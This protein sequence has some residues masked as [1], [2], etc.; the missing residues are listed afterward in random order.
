MSTTTH[1]AATAAQPAALTAALDWRYAVKKFDPT[2]RVPDAT[3]SVLEHALVH[4]PS[5]YGLQ[6]W[7]FVVVADPALRARLREVSWKQSQVTDASHFV[8]FA[9]RVGIDSAYVQHYVER[10]AAVRGVPLES[11]N[12]FRDM[13]NKAI[14][15][16]G[17]KADA[18]S[19]RQ[20][21]IALGALLTAAAV[22]GVDA[23]PMEGIDGPRYDELLGLTPLGYR[24]LCAAAVGYR[25]ADDANAALRKVRFAPGEVILRR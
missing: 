5:S 10:I 13:M 15:G 12:G 25:A 24:S 3:W 2:R 17:E 22:L 9:S 14:A 1:S 23:C 4:A 16:M 7:R 8:V 19:A 6:P 21:Y 20:T 18:W 11:L